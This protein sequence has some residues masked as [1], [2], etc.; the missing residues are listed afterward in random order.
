[1]RI[2]IAYCVRFA[3]VCTRVYFKL[4]TIKIVFYKL[5]NVEH[6]TSAHGSRS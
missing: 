4:T 1:M 5:F 6:E 3:Y 2:K